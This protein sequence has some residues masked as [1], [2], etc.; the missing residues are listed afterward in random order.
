MN[1][2]YHIGGNGIEYYC[3]DACLHTEITHEEYMELYDDGEGDSYWTA[4]EDPDDFEDEDED[5]AKE[6]SPEAET[7]Q[8]CVMVKVWVWAENEADAKELVSDDM[9]FLLQR[10]PR[11]QGLMLSAWLKIRRYDM[12][13][14]ERLNRIAVALRRAYELVE[15]G[16]EAHGYIAEALAYADGDLSSFDGEV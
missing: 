10:T 2:G 14:H 8:F 11:L 9:S 13:E 6:P 7:K 16:S 12:N 5:E 3:S 1:E 4:W 15:E